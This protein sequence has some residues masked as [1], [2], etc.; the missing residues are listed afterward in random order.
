MLNHL[1]LAKRELLHV[2]IWANKP[3]SGSH[4]SGGAKVSGNDQTSWCCVWTQPAHELIT[5][6]FMTGKTT[7]RTI[8][9]HYGC[10]WMCSNLFW[11]PQG[12]KVGGGEG[13]NEFLLIPVS[14]HVKPKIVLKD[15]L[16]AR[17]LFMPVWWVPEKRSLQVTMSICRD[18]SIPLEVRSEPLKSV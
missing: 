18:V 4:L 7:H 9:S 12:L 15:F 13:S 8:V 2:A 1:T 11:H 10:C 5:G 3:D 16:K 17:F 6:R 14:D